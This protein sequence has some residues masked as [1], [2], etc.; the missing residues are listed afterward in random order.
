MNSKIA[1]S[2]S[3]ARR[4]DLPQRRPA[5]VVDDDDLLEDALVGV[6]PNL[7]AP[8]IGGGGGGEGGAG[9]GREGSPQQ[10]RIST[11]PSAACRPLMLLRFKAP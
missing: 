8:D 11:D 7:M 6:L 2:A 10:E 9:A 1:E 4:H 5:A 3:K